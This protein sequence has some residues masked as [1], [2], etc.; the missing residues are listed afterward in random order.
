MTLSGQKQCQ[1]GHATAADAR[2]EKLL[3]RE[4]HY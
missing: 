3:E 2:K 1:G 4:D